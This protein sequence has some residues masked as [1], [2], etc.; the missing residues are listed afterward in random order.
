MEKN[1]EEKVRDFVKFVTEELN[2]DYVICGSLALKTC[3][4]PVNRQPKDLD[5]R[6]KVDEKSKE[7][8]R[9]LAAACEEPLKYADDNH[10]R[11][12]WKGLIVDIWLVEKIEGEFVWKDY[13]KYAGVS[14]VLKEKFR[15]ARCKDVSDF[16]FA[17][18][19]FNGY[20]PLQE[21]EV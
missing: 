11:I 8:L 13:L 21:E 14:S 16:I 15:Y 12:S 17:I 5:I 4:F 1:F 20:F 9:G 6:I 7:I 3:G 2:G 18:D 10:F 19:I